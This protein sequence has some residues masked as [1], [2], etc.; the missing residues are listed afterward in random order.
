M[1]ALYLLLLIALA[2]VFTHAYE[3]WQDIKKP[4]GF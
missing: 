2:A 4:R 3:M 1:I